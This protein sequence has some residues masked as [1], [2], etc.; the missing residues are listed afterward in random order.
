MRRHPCYGQSVLLSVSLLLSTFL[1]LSLI[2]RSLYL[3]ISRS[4]ATLV[5]NLNCSTSKVNALILPAGHRRNAYGIPLFAALSTS[6]YIR[7]PSRWV[8]SLGLRARRTGNISTF[9]RSLDI[10]WPAS[11]SYNYACTRHHRSTL[12]PSRYQLEKP[13]E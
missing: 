5:T 3:A 4:H 9:R 11:V 6:L 12:T 13:S 7:K 1:T 10:S 8:P 2:L